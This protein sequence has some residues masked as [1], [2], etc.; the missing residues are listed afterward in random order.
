[1]KSPT[2]LLKIV[3]V[4]TL[5][6]WFWQALSA[7]TDFDEVMHGTALRSYTAMLRS[8][9]TNDLEKVS[10]SMQPIQPL[11]STLSTKASM[12]FGS[13]INSG[14]SGK[15]AL[16]VRKGTVTLIAYD[17]CLLVEAVPKD[18]EV[19]DITT[20]Q[21]RIR[22]GFNLYK[23]SSPH[24]AE[25]YKTDVNNLSLQFKL[26]LQSLMQGNTANVTKYSDSISKK[27]RSSVISNL[28]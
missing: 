13:R 23:L 12:D 19:N 7:Q 17:I 5:L 27:L 9:V 10:F 15:N 24:L 2:I 6:P 18:L 11:I 21:K 8:S 20:A 25:L 16:R 28:N 14:I 1:M 22:Y 4:L 26:L 3:L